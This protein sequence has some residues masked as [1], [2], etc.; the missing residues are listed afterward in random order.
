MYGYRGHNLFP[1]NLNKINAVS[2]RKILEKKSSQ[3]NGLQHMTRIK[4]ACLEV[5]FTKAGVPWRTQTTREQRLQGH[6]GYHT[7]IFVNY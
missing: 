3:N 5:I 6:S 7:R 2:C 1:L 4:E